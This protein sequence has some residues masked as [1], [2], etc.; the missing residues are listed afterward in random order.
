MGVKKSVC[1]VQAFE[2]IY[3][4]APVCFSPKLAKVVTDELENSSVSSK[5]E[6]PQD[7]GVLGGLFDL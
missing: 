4:N 6:E 2:D 5:E 3:Y 7:D 1:S